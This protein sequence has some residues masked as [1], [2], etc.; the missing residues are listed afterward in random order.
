MRC[1]ARWTH[2]EFAYTSEFEM[3]RHEEQMKKDGWFVSS[4]KRLFGKDTEFYREYR[5]RQRAGSFL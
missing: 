4:K 1:L 3:K 2:V 5:I